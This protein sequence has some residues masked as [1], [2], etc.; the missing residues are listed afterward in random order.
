M[1]SEPVTIIEEEQTDETR[2]EVLAALA[3]GGP[4]VLLSAV[5]HP[6]IDGGVR[7]ALDA[8]GDIRDQ[9]DIVKFLELALRTLKRP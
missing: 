7:L 9:D 4:Y 3:G 2:A 5:A 8:G 1:P 6:D